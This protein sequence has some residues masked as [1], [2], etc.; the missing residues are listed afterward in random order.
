[1]KNIRIM[2]GVSGGK[3]TDRTLTLPA[4]NT[5]EAGKIYNITR[6]YSDLDGGGKE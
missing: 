2:M 4:E 3:G 5:T 1:V 6:N